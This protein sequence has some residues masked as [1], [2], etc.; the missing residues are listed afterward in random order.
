[1]TDTVSLSFVNRDAGST[2]T[3]QVEAGAAPA[4]A[5][6][7]GA[8]HAGDDYDVMIDGETVEKTINGEID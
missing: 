3:M 4:I 8:Y 7:Y 5:R 1:M 6:W 2:D